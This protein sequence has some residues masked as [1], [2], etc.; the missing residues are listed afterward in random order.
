MGLWITPDALARRLGGQVRG[1]G[2]LGSASISFAIQGRPAILDLAKMEMQDSFSR[3]KSGSIVTELSVD[4]W[5]ISPGAIKISQRG[6]GD[7]FSRIFRRPP[8]RVGDALFDELYVVRSEPGHLAEALFSP[9]RRAAVMG[10]VRRIG[11]YV[12]PRIDL[13]SRR[14]SVHVSENLEHERGIQ[15]LIDTATDFVTY[16]LDLRGVGDMTWDGA[17]KEQG[18]K[19]PVCN[20]PLL[21]RLVY[22][23]D[24]RT[25]HH[26]DCWSYMGKCSMFGCRGT[27]ASDHLVP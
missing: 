22:C 14:L 2:W 5:G 23:A 4:L 11:T 3:S 8:F 16:V 15:N 17:L 20:A 12:E 27:K 18:G 25:P 13:S 7:F 19:C 24:C 26:E 6:V 1:G 10:S 21:D 9:S